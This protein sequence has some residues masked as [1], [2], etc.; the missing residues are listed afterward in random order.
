MKRQDIL[1][2]RKIGSA[3]SVGIAL[4]TLGSL[5]APQEVEY[6]IEVK[7]LSDPDNDGMLWPVNQELDVLIHLLERARSEGKP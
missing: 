5:L 4:V 1:K 3:G 6:F 7:D 2:W